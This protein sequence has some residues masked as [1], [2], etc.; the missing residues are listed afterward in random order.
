[1]KSNICCYLLVL[2]CLSGCD[3]INPEEQLPIYVE[4]KDARVLVDE[5][6]QT[7]STLGIKDGWVFQQNQMV[8]VFQMPSTFPILLNEGVDSLRIGGGVF[9]T[10]LSS[11]RLEYPFWDDVNVS[12]AG[13]EPLDTL[14]VRPRFRYFERDS[15]L[16]YAFEEGFEGASVILQS[17]QPTVKHTRIDPSTEDRFVGQFS[18]K[19]VFSPDRYIME[20]SSPLL[21]LPQSGFN[22]I[23]CEVTYK[24]D[25]P[26]SVLLVGLA[27]GS[28]FEQEL[29]TNVVFGSPDGWNTVYIHLNDLA[30]SLS[31]GAAFKLVFRAS[32]YDTQLQQGRDGYLFLDHIRLIHFKS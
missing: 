17:Q 18:G 24:N 31:N 15:V 5:Q 29:P 23:W 32:S 27:P 21:S 14:V 30:R 22:D 1:M 13:I 28:V 6:R 19:V 16:I 12:L 4:V 20:L 2:G 9:E 10:G 11:F 26:F 8:G 25:I 3:L 7:W